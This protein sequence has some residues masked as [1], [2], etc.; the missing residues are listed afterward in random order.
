MMQKMLKLKILR[1][2]LEA[3]EEN[4]PTILNTLLVQHPS[5]PPDTLLARVWER[6]KSM[7][8]K[9]Y[10]EFA[11][12]RDGW[13]PLTP[14]ERGLL[15]PP[16]NSLVWDSATSRWCWREGRLGPEPPIVILTDD[17]AQYIRGRL[18]REWRQIP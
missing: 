2:L 6:L 10:I 1:M 7:E 11:W 16:A 8:K 9:S 12:Y 3:G 14:E 18:E 13:V 17:G 15:L 4:L 5:E